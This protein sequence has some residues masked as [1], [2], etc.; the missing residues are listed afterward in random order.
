MRAS[1]RLSIQWKITLLTGTCLLFIV[2]LLVGA[3][4]YQARRTAI[5]V[6]QSS[7][8][9]LEASAQDTLEAQGNT[10]ALRIQ[11]QFGVASLLCCP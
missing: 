10:Q 6:R 4:L 8:S 9:M 5:A 7:S 3:A 11:R 1:A 2:A